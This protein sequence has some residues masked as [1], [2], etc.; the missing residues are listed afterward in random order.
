[1][2]PRT[3]KEEQ[4]LAVCQQEEQRREGRFA[5]KAL[6]VPTSTLLAMRQLD[7]PAL[8]RNRSRKRR[9]VDAVEVKK[10]EH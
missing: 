4:L 2:M 1:M 8:A 7:Y 10:T 9:R 5:L 3:D 6:Q